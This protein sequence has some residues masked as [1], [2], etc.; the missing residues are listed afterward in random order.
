MHKDE[1]LDLSNVISFNLDEYYPIQPDS[2]QSYHRFMWD[3]FFSHVNIPKENVH[4]PDGTIA[5][6]DVDRFCRD[7]ELAIAEAGATAV[8][9]P[10]GSVRDDDVIAAADDAGL[11]MVFTGMR[12]F[13]H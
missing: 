3:N 1:G 12:H 2:L 4:I 8:I 7:Y 10:G 5:R 11:A 13:R 6:G 9:Q